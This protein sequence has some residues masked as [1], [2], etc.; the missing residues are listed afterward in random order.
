MANKNPLAMFEILAN[1]QAALIA[2]YTSVFEWE[3]DYD[4]AGFGYVHFPP[5]ARHLLGGIGKADPGMPGWEKGTAFYIE[6]ADLES[7][8]DTVR[9]NGGEVVVAPISIDT[10][11]FAMFSDPESNLIGIIEPFGD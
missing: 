7:T 10:Y 3:L 11:R 4:G 5:A 8:L 2:F 1:D 6:V 9:A